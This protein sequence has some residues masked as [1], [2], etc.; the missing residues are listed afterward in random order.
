MPSARSP[1]GREQGLQSSAELTNICL[2]VTC[3]GA[4]T[5]RMVLGPRGGL[6]R[7]TDSPPGLIPV[8]MKG[9]ILLLTESEY[10]A[11][12]RR[13][14][15]WRRRVATERR[16]GQTAPTAPSAEEP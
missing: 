11:G 3:I 2:S 7:P 10:L 14:K 1:H 8:P 4:R 15:W 13:G 12:V 9:A 16:T 5:A 6:E